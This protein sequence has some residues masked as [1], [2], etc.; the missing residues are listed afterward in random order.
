MRQIIK[1]WI[2][3]VL[4]VV[5]S[6]LSLSALS[7]SYRYDFD[8]LEEDDWEL[9]GDNSVWQ[10][11]DGFLRAAIQPNDF[12]AALF[13]F[14]GI[15]GNYE[16]FEIF[17]N[18]RLIQRQEKKTGHESFTITVNNFGSKRAIIGVAIGQRFPEVDKGFVFFY[19]FNTTGIEAKSYMWLNAGPCWKKEPRH[20]DTFWET[21]ELT[22]MEI[23]FNRGHF[24]WFVD[25]ERRAEFEDPNFS[26]IEIIGFLMQA[27]IVNVGSAWVDSFTI[28]G[29]GL[30]VSPQAKLATTWGQYKQLR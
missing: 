19:V 4:I 5:L 22:S 21:W 10:V 24:Q 26:Q 23:R 13:Q 2:V 11:E 12:N 1:T 15:P 18:D 27:S 20:P 7:E 16:K 30:A 8:V 29:S 28:S 3:M 6:I 17:V 14:I 9:W 25:D